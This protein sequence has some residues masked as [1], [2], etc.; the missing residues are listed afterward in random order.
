MKRLCTDCGA[1][2]HLNRLSLQCSPC[3]LRE[4]EYTY[5]AREL[6]DVLSHPSGSLDSDELVIYEG[7]PSDLEPDPLIV[8]ASDLE[9]ALKG[10]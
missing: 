5:W 3:E 9:S 4:A 6:K 1:H 10:Y 7:E 8:V 2:R